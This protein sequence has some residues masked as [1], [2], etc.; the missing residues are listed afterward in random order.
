MKPAEVIRERVRN[1]YGT[2][3]GAA[4]GT[5]CS[6]SGVDFDADQISRHL[7]YTDQ[8]L[9]GVPQGANLGLGCGSPAA[10]AKIKAGETVVDLGSGAGFD[11][12]LAA[13]K[14]GPK[15]RVIGVDMTPEMVSRARQNKEKTGAENI[16]FR[17]GEIE[18][19][20]IGDETADLIISN[21]VINLA[22]EKH[23][24]FKEAFRVLKPG[25]RLAISDILALQPLPE[26]LRQDLAM[27]S[28][29]IG[30]A[31]T[32]ADTKALLESAGFS[33]ISIS[34]RKVSPDILNDLLPGSSIDAYVAPADITAIKT[35]A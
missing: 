1:D 17:L 8:D 19:L 25:G 28:A 29:C 22:P 12:F 16:S 3:A 20:P 23:A 11:C 14:V 27:V 4:D 31:A 32:V 13:G 21:C 35:A 7:G 5:G 24:V 34:T 6:C 2:I 15:G 9:A 33:R 30:G 26:Q 10:L 18:H